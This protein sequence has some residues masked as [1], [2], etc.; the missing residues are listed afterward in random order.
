VRTPRA[1]WG[2]SAS[3]VVHL[4]LT[5]EQAAEALGLGR[6]LVYELIRT[7]RLTSVRIGRARRIPIASLEAFVAALPHAGP[8][9]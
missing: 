5:P 4:L 6:T 9:E 7:G 1:S 2:L 8:N 3:P